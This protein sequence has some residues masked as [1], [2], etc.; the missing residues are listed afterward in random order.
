MTMTADE[1]SVN[2]FARGF[3]KRYGVEW[4]SLSPDQRDAWRDQVK[5]LLDYVDSTGFR[6]FLPLP[7]GVSS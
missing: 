1:K 2:Q 3:A 7:E 6:G 5:Q 4:A